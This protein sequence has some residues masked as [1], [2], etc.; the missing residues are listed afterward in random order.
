[1]GVRTKYPRT[2]FL[3]AVNSKYHNLWYFQITSKMQ[4]SYYWWVA[5]KRLRFG[6][7]THA[8]D[9]LKKEQISRIVRN[10]A[11][12]W[13][14]TQITGCDVL[15][16]W[17]RIPDVNEVTSL[18]NVGFIL[19]YTVSACVHEMTSKFIN[20]GHWLLPANL[21]IML[22]RG[23]YALVKD[24]QKYFWTFVII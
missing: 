4:K 2:Y 9:L 8:T 12:R 1:M 6:N 5:C 22:K 13:K 18:R 16:A 20:I 15:D 23:K 17:Q 11:K 14:D 7:F 10:T 3:I 19:V 21:I 24:L